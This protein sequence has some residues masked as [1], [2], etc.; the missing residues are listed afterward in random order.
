MHAGRKS[1]LARAYKEHADAERH[2]LPGAPPLD[3]EAFLAGFQR[4]TMS[5]RDVLRA[6]GILG[7]G[8]ALAACTPS[9]PSLRAVAHVAG[10]RPA[11]HAAHRRGGRRARGHHRCLPALARRAPRPGVRGTGPPR[12]PM[13]DL[14]RLGAKDRPPSTA[15]SSSIR[16]TCTS[17]GSP[18]S[19]TSASTISGRGM[20]RTRATHASWRGRDLTVHETKPVMARI[21][22]AAAEE[23]RKIGLTDGAGTVDMRAISYG[24]ATAAA[25]ALDQRSMSEWLDGP[26]PGRGGLPRRH[27]GST[28]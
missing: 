13:L 27:G 20:S 1:P 22:A 3:F 11:H 24:T 17:E 14:A 6:G 4:P 10:G 7:A 21:N 23:A 9:S 19:S 5:R 28:R 2:R 16:A 18:A 8:V 26:R 15:A 12:W 25:Q